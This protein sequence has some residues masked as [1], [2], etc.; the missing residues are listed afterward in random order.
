MAKKDGYYRKFDQDPKNPTIVKVNSG[1]GISDEEI[2]SGNAQRDM[3]ELISE[4][5]GKGKIRK[6]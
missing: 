6:N 4:R 2:Q 3:K 1:A 5:Y